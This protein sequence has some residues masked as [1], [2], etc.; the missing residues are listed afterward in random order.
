MLLVSNRIYFLRLQ[1]TNLVVLDLDRFRLLLKSGY[2]DNTS[3]RRTLSLPVAFGYASPNAQFVSRESLVL[4]SL[5]IRT[6][7]HRP[8]TLGIMLTRK[9]LL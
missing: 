3:T 5:D 1:L 6:N 7:V 4:M 2:L 8:N 9:G